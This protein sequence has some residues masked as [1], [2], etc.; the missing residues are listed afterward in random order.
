[1]TTLVPSEKHIICESCRNVDN[2]LVKI[3]TSFKTQ[4][5]AILAPD[6]RILIDL[7]E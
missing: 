2:R 7:N 4:D 3:T 6:P 1:M 5:P